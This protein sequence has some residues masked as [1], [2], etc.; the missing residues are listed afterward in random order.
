M[1]GPFLLQSFSSP[2]WKFTK[3]D[4]VQGGALANSG[5]EAGADASRC[6]IRMKALWKAP[7]M[8]SMALWARKRGNVHQ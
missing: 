4:A 3:G 8:V 1:P 7:E 2:G 6:E 5:D